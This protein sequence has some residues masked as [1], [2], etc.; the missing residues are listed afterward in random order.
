MDQPALG[1]LIVQLR[2]AKGLTQEEI[3]EKCNVSVRTLQRIESG[4]ASPRN[5]TIRSI[6]A[7]LEYTAPMKDSNDRPDSTGSV[8]SRRLEQVYKYLVDLFN[9]RTNTMKKISILTSTI[10][11]ISFALVAIYSDTNAQS[12]AEAKKSIELLDKKFVQ[13]FNSAKTDSILTL[14]TEDACIQG[15]ICGMEFIKG[16]Y[17][18]LT[19]KSRFTEFESHEIIVDGSSAMEKGKWSM[20]LASGEEVSGQFMTEWK[21]LKGRWYIRK[22]FTSM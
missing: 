18:S 6:F 22:D 11:V 12:A 13:W 21:F 1:K 4:E 5:Y 2:K 3:V 10:V 9:L 7:A 14:Y 17:Q 20:I 8:A 16:Y 19:G 15:S